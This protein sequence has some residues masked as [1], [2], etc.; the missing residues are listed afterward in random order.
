MTWPCVKA[1]EGG[2]SVFSSIKVICSSC[3]SSNISLKQIYPINAHI[4][5]FA[6]ALI[7]SVTSLDLTLGTITNALRWRWCTY[8]WQSHKVRKL[9]GKKLRKLMTLQ[10]YVPNAPLTLEFDRSHCSKSKKFSPAMFARAF[11]TKIWIKIDCK[12]VGGKIKTQKRSKRTPSK[13]KKN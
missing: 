12:R 1:D 11:M 8:L 10:F 3:N 7:S 6:Q 9:L 13:K 2:T 5:V 4:E